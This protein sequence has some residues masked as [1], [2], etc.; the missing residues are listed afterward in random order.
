MPKTQP[1]PR[2][3]RDRR[4]GNGVRK[5]PRAAQKPSKAKRGPAASFTHPATGGRRTLRAQD[6]DVDDER[7]WMDW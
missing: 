5:R 6:A 3:G 1:K 2:V 4:A 7:A